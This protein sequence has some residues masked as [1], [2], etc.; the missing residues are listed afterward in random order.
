[1]PRNWPASKVTGAFTG[2][3]LSLLRKFLMHP[4]LKMEPVVGFAQPS[5]LKAP[6]NQQAMT[7]LMY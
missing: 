2:G 5:N 1:M 7:S 3:Y 6:R 4:Q